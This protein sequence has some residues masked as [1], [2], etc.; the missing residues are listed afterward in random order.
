MGS[1]YVSS[2]MG[3]TIPC[4]SRN[5]EHFHVVTNDTEL[6]VREQWAQPDLAQIANK[7]PGQ[8]QTLKLNI[9]LIRS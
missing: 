5:L 7:K 9:M 4:E 1:K 3:M 6:V 2:K 8:A